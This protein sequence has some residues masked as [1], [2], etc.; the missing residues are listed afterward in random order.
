LDDT[1]ADIFTVNETE[2]KSYFQTCAARLHVRLRIL[3]GQ[4]SFCLGQFD[5]SKKRVFGVE[6]FLF[7][8][9]GVG[10][11]FF[12]GMWGQTHVSLGK[13]GLILWGGG[14]KGFIF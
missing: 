13:V 5:D 9:R 11:I 4:G 8:L 2:E 1:C 3:P 6:F 14:G 7:L 10:F 12:K